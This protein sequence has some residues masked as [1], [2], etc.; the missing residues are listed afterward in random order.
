MLTKNADPNQRSAGKIDPP[1]EPQP[2]PAEEQARELLYVAEKKLLTAIMR[3]EAMRA[4][5]KAREFFGP[6]VKKGGGR[7]DEAHAKLE[8]DLR[9]EGEQIAKLKAEQK[10]RLKKH[11]K[12][13]LEGLKKL[14]AREI[15]EAIEDSN[16][17]RAARAR[18]GD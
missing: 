6:T 9:R 18:S 7:P 15:A 17:S 14:R 3:A 2:N 1:I 8:E 16:K 11:L 4:R 5:A 13:H 10:T 12:E